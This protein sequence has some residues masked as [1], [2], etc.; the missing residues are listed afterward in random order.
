MAQITGSRAFERFSGNQIMKIYHE[1]KDAY[2]NTEVIREKHE[3]HIEKAYSGRFDSIS[4]IPL[5][6]AADLS[7]EQFSG[8]IIHRGLR[9]N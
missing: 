5:P 3:S 4:L 8:I 6:F 1:Q 7:G 9:S 2:L